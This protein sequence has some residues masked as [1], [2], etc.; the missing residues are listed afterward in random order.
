MITNAE[1]SKKKPAGKPGARFLRGRKVCFTIHCPTKP[2]ELPAPDWVSYLIYGEERGKR[3]VTP[4]F[5]G[6]AEFSRAVVASTLVKWLNSCG[7]KAPYVE[8]PIASA[9]KN[10]NYC[11][12]E[13]GKIVTV[14]EFRH[15]QGK[16]TDLKGI[17]DA[18]REGMALEDIAHEFPMDYVKYHKGIIAWK[19]AMRPSRNYTTPT[20]T[21]LWGPTGTGKSHTARE[22]MRGPSGNELYWVWSPSRDRWFDGYEGEANVIFEEFR[23]QLPLGDMLMLLDKYECP[24]QYKGGSTEFVGTNIVFTSPTH[25]REWYHSVGS[26][27]IDQLMRR[28]TTITH[29]A[30]RYVPPPDDPEPT[31]PRLDGDS[32]ST[33]LP[34]LPTAES[35]AEL[36]VTPQGGVVDSDGPRDEPGFLGSFE[37]RLLG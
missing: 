25:P 5:Q 13:C 28:I 32:S 6:Y 24:V 20:V 36:L 27:K 19:A 2:I 34:P 7:G 1:A 14:G 23:G 26:D 30:D 4:H 31:G 21:V 18:L 33:D 12:K 11:S 17:G 16:R 35:I 9:E 22:M 29:M 8:I 3:G 15:E 37:P 10:R